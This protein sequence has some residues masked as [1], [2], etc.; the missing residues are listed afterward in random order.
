MRR[1]V[2][3]HLR[4]AGEEA[5]AERY[6]EGAS[7]VKAVQILGEE[8]NLEPFSADSHS[9]SLELC[10]IPTETARYLSV[11]LSRHLVKRGR[12]QVSKSYL[13]RLTYRMLVREI[14]RK[15]AQ[16][17]LVWRQFKRS[18]TPLLL[19]IGGTAG[20]GK[21]TLATELASRLDI[22]RTQSTDML[23]EIMRAMLPE[24][25][26]PILHRS[27]FEAWR[28][29]PETAGPLDF[30]DKIA[31]GYRGQTD[32][33]SVLCEA[34]V[35]RAVRENVSMV[36]EGVHI[37]AST[38]NRLRENDEIIV[39][40]VMLAI[41]KQ[42]VWHKR[43]R[44]RGRA[45]TQRRAQRYLKSFDAIWQLQSQLLSDADGNDITIVVNDDRESTIDEVLRIIGDTLSAHLEPAL[46]QV[47]PSTE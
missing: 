8:G 6:A 30:E 47:F 24:R 19:L 28:V 3:E 11:M 22:F 17:Y 29:L 38:V 18:G 4:K 40:P 43:I 5:I 26:L 33:V 44:G 1:L 15:S 12:A 23:R 41:L 37:D 27:S 45:A 39:I 35:Q 20:S 32:L 31:H 2:A 14:D 25:L 9:K 42:E 10:G 36:L 34:V 16:R 46:K 7:V 13:G 21:S